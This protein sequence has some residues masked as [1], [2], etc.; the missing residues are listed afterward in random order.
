P[1][2]HPQLLEIVDEALSRK[3]IIRI[4]ISTNGLELLLQPN[5]LSELYKRNVVVSLQFDGFDDHVYEVLRGQKLLNKKLEI[6]NL[7]ADIGISTSLTVTVA[8]TVNEN[9]FS[10]ILKYF[11]SQPHIISLMIQPISFA[12]R[13]A[14]LSGHIKRLSITDIIRLLS[15][16]GDLRVKAE[17]FVPLP[18]SHPLCFSLAY[19]LMLNDGGTISLNRLVDASK[20]MDSLANRT[21]FGLDSQ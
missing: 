20:L 17:D 13:A 7:L 12:G 16:S 4:S 18:C 5:L 19:Y 2:I 11:F 15:G 14:N 10:D 1:L 9:Q 3:E 21:I 8:G 6:L